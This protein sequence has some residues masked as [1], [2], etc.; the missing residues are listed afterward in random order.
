M[1][2][3]S[4]QLRGGMYTEGEINWCGSIKDTKGAHLKRPE[5]HEPIWALGPGPAYVS[6]TRKLQTVVPF[7]EIGRKLTAMTGAPTTTPA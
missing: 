4:K 3:S 1:P 2:Q 5:D 7:N 6:E